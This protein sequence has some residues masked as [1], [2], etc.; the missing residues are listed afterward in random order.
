MVTNP[1]YMVISR[2]LEI[3]GDAAGVD[4]IEVVK[5]HKNG[6][7]LGFLFSGEKFKKEDHRTENFLP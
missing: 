2:K 6:V 5:A 3:Y 4:L 7:Y 1:G